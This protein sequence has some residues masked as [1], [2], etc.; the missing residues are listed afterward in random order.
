MDVRYETMKFPEE[1]SKLP[2]VSLG[3]NGLDLTTKAKVSEWCSM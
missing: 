1:R 2:E 3:H